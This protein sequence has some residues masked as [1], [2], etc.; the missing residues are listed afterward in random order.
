MVTTRKASYINSS[1]DR[2]ASSSSKRRRKSASS[3]LVSPPSSSKRDSSQSSG[4]PVGPIALS[5]STNRESQIQQSKDVVQPDHTVSRQHEE[6]THQ[7]QPVPPIE[8]GEG[9]LELR[10]QHRI[11]DKEQQTIQDSNFDDISEYVS[12]WLIAVEGILFGDLAGSLGRNQVRRLHRLD[13]EKIWSYD[14]EYF[15]DLGGVARMLLCLKADDYNPEI[16]GFVGDVFSMC[17]NDNGDRGKLNANKTATMIVKRNGIE[18]L[19]RANDECVKKM[20]VTTTRTIEGRE[21]LKHIVVAIHKIWKVT[22]LVFLN[23][24]N[25]MTTRKIFHS[26]LTSLEM[27]GNVTNCIDKE[28]EEGTFLHNIASTVMYHVF[29]ILRQVVKCA[30]IETE[31]SFSIIHKGILKKCVDILEN[32]PLLGFYHGR[33][34]L[35][36]VCFVFAFFKKFQMGTSKERFQWFWHDGILAVYVRYLRQFNDC[37]K[38]IVQVIE[39]IS[40]E[41]WVTKASL[42]Q[43]HGIASA[44]TAVLESNA[45]V[46]AKNRARML[47][48]FLCASE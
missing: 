4:S 28:S 27:V 18:S 41:G 38:A 25:L 15:L 1:D 5:Y 11:D 47:L 45:R 43:E 32:G 8:D 3:Q 9:E 36:A 17:L 29:A 34:F 42:L 35:E 26:A 30:S 23:S 40:S 6:N 31:E 7:A 21:Q 46:N 19:L 44:L 22:R 13:F 12:E 16:I 33:A 37:P 14:M 20:K 39:W 10:S 2:K 48:K 24:K